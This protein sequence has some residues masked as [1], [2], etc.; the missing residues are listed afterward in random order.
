MIGLLGGSFDPV[1]HGHLIVAQVAREALGLEALGSSPP[2]NSRSRGAATARRR[3]IGLPC[4]HGRR[5]RWV[6]RRASE[7]DRPGPS[8]TVDTLR[9]AAGAG[10]G[11]RF[12]LLL[13]AD[14][15]AEL[16]AWHGAGHPRARPGGRVRPSGPPVPPPADRRASRSPP[17]TSRPPR[18]VGGSGREARSGSWSPTP[19]PAYIS[20]GAIL[21]S[22][23]IK[24]LMTAVFGTRFDRDRKR[25]QPIVDAIHAPRGA[26]R[27]PLRS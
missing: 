24:S 17:S 11:A 7:L 27:D 23:M 25:I 19:W 5:A 15:A 16:A 4:W 21:G 13:G 6:R 3:S 22:R 18:S 9:R 2:G 12:V 1:H 8:Y 10:A 14:A 20:R 26:A